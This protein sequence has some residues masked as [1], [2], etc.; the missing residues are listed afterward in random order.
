MLDVGTDDLEPVVLASFVDGVVRYG[1]PR[2]LD[3]ADRDG[4]QIVELALDLIID[5]RSAFGTEVE[6][7]RVAAVAGLHEASRIAVDRHL[8]LRPA[9]LEGE[10]A[11]RPLLAIEAMA[12][13][14]ADG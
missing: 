3:R 7:R 8:R 6:G 4:D 10:G 5:V 13:G 12:D 14:D 2:L 9:R 11:S 1:E